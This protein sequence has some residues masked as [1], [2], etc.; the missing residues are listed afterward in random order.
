MDSVRYIKKENVKDKCVLV[1][2]IYRNAMCI[3]E[4]G[5][6]IIFYNNNVDK[7]PKFANVNSFLS[8]KR[9]ELFDDKE[10]YQEV[11]IGLKKY[12]KAKTILDY[13]RLYTIIREKHKDTTRVFAK[14]IKDGDNAIILQSDEMYSDIFY[15]S[16]EELKEG[17][18]T[19]DR[20]T[21]ISNE[22]LLTKSLNKKR[23]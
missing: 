20:Q 4:D 21:T 5:K 17:K 7:N 1:E 12:I 10:P 8:D 6:G 3:I 16:P 15:L 9:K 13:D 23:C 22:G 19:K 14:V 2:F 18:T 11:R